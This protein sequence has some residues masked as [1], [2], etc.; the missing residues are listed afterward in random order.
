MKSPHF[1][2]T[3]H[4]LAI[5]KRS[6][7]SS[8]KRRFHHYD[9]RLLSEQYLA[10]FSDRQD[11][12][13]L[14]SHQQHL[15]LLRPQ[16]TPV[17]PGVCRVH[18]CKLHQFHQRLQVSS[19]CKSHQLHQDSTHKSA[20]WISWMMFELV[21]FDIAT[22]HSRRSPTADCSHLKWKSQMV[23]LTTPSGLLWTIPTQIPKQPFVSH[24]FLTFQ[25]DTRQS[26]AASIAEKLVATNRKLQ[27]DWTQQE[28][29]RMTGGSISRSRA[30]DTQ[31]LRKRSDFNQALSALERLQQE[32]GEEPYV[33]IYSCKH[34]Q[35]QLVQSSSSTRWNWQDSWWSS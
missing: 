23:H 28:F 26:L 10:K 27:L 1:L 32:A 14:P 4:D 15:Q 6:V 30:N 21:S 31:P 18:T 2:S 3:V 25:I 9:L 22:Q 35:W 12:T 24:S 7:Q 20:S 5:C 11:L 19:F 16:T 8:Q 33:P 34:K 13:A 17:P 29:N